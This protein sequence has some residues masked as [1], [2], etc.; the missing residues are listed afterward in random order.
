MKAP[1]QPS[2][3]LP[4]GGDH[5]ITYLDGMR[6]VAVVGVMCGHYFSRWAPPYNDESLYPYGQ[7]WSGFLPFKYGTVGVDLFFI[8]S[9][10]VITLTLAKCTRPRDFAA[11]RYARLAPAMLLLSAM[12]FVAEKIIPESPF[13][14]SAW[15]FASSLT[16]IHPRI[17]N[18]LFSTDR[19]ASMDGAYWSL[20]VEVKYYLLA[21]AVYYFDR[22]AFARNMVL[23]STLMVFGYLLSAAA[24]P[25]LSGWIELWLFPEFIPWFVL[26]IGFYLHF[27]GA[28]RRHWVSVAAAGLLQLICLRYSYRP[29]WGMAVPGL[30]ALFFL[31]AMHSR[32]L[33]RLLSARPLVAVGVSSYGLYFLHENVGV[34]LIHALPGFFRVHPFAGIA[35]ALLTMAGCAGIAYASFVFV[36]KPANRVLLRLLSSR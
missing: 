15:D 33:Q 31:A 8:I 29:S 14:S 36:E 5:R 27:A 28:T 6:C 32:A 24:A 17:L 13:Q 16:F 20:Y 2:Q 11:R 9:G 18:L 26:G 35:A 1:L 22:A 3:P 21:A 19:F 12:T 7:L 10:F 34:A 4:I 30:L 23:V 25:A